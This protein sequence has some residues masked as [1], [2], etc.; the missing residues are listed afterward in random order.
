MFDDG[1]YPTERKILMMKKRIDRA[2]SS[3]RKKK[4]DFM[5]KKGI[6][7][8]GHRQLSIRAA[9]KADYM[10]TDAESR[11]IREEQV[12]DILF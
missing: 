9:R 11:Q 10:G 5:L 1:N 7:P 8:Q 3:I 6:W 12:V 2:T 4:W